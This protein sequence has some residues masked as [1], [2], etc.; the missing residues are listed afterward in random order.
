MIQE[1]SQWLT[2]PCLEMHQPI[3]TFYV[4]VLQAKRLGRLS[5]VD[6]RQ[7][8]L[9]ERELDKYVG[10]QRVLDE[11]RVEE[12]KM[13]VETVDAS[14]P[15][16]IVVA[17]KGKDIRYDPSA[18]QAQLRDGEDVAKIIDGQHRMA[19]LADYDRDDFDLMVTLFVDLEIENQALLFATI[20][21]AQ[22][23]VNKSL[24]YDLYEFA[25]ARSPQKT[26]HNI[27]RLLNGEE[28]SPFQGKFKILGI[29]E[30]SEE[31][32]S[33][34]LFAEALIPLLSPDPLGEREL[35]KGNK[36][37]PALTEQDARSKI[38]AGMFRE[39]DDAKIAKTVWNYFEAVS[40]RWPTAWLNVQQGNILNRTTGFRGL[41]M[42]LPAAYRAYGKPEDVPPLA[43]FERLFA[44]VNLLDVNFSSVNFQTGSGGQSKLRNQLLEE[45][46]LSLP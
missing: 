40:K 13:Y 8:E 22:T 36:K 1:K 31:T 42:F 45:T 24:V 17:V 5:F 10:I 2:F 7:L 18:G 32:I 38:F 29:A 20:N 41:M 39:D 4:G 46:G 44:K 23:K 3:G 30:S 16:P 43:H 34:A 26:A 35:L 27:V 15:A 9:G 21:L 28:G 11:R 6:R 37:L 14:F 19:G 33:Q 12:I 25:R